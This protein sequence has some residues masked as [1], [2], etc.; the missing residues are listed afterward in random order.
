MTEANFFKENYSKGHDFC[1]L[2]PSDPGIK[3]NP[4]DGTYGVSTY[5]QAR[6]VCRLLIIIMIMII[7]IPVIY[8]LMVT[9]SGSRIIYS[10]LLTFSAL[11]VGW[12]AARASSL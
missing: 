3:L 1:R 12:V 6:S 7:I 11:T 5:R 2:N 9:E 10:S 4:A 8:S